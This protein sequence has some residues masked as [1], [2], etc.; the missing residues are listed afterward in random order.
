M[1]IGSGKAPSPSSSKTEL[2]SSSSTASKPPKISPSA[3]RG[4][5]T[6]GGDTSECEDESDTSA[7]DKD[8]LAPARCQPPVKCKPKYR[9]YGF[10]DFQLVKVLGKG[11]FGKVN[12]LPSL[13]L[14]FSLSFQSSINHQFS[15]PI[16]F[17]M[18]PDHSLCAINQWASK[19]SYSRWNV[20]LFPSSPIRLSVVIELFK[21]LW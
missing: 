17:N 5:D 20:W 11:S 19:Q 6:S 8:D 18:K 13:F 3:S 7:T 4:S 14:S 21:V 12:L 10:E 15:Y 2:S 9:K 16:A 1:V